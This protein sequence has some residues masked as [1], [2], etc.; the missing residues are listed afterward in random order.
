PTSGRGLGPQAFHKPALLATR[1]RPGNLSPR[2][3]RPNKPVTRHTTM[4]QNAA[5]QPGDVYLSFNGIDAYVEVPGLEAYSA[6]GPE[7]L[8]VSA[9]MRPDVLNFP[10]AEGTGYVHWLGKG[11]G[12]GPG[13][14]QEWTFR[15]Y[16]RD[17]TQESPP[18]PNRI[19]F[20]VFNP[21]GGLGVGS[22]V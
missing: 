14:V 8:T 19:S 17:G 3:G 2:P 5:P 9:W 21:E 10:N 1:R 12:A 4:A 22:Y 15:M 16:N 11:E 13:G 6:A 7:G 18:R 20:Y